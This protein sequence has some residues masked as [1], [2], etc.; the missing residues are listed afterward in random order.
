VR[1]GIVIYSIPGLSKCR[2]N[3][4]FMNAIRN[5]VEGKDDEF[6]YTAY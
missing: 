1:T 2:S 5:T 4:L 6:T 3:F